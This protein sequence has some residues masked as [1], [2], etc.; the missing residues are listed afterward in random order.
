MNILILIVDDSESDRVTY[1]RYLQSE[2]EFDY[3]FLEAET[4]EE[5]IE[6]WN[7]QS[8]QLVLVDI[9]LPDGSGLEL[10][11]V[12]KQSYFEPFLPVI[13]VTGL[14]D[15]RIAVEA[16][17]LGA[18]DYLVKNY[19]TQSALCRSVC[20][21]IKQAIASRQLI[22]LEQQEAIISQISLHIHEK[23]DLKDIYQS[24]V[25]DVREF[26]AADRVV[27]YKFNEDMS[28][29]IVAESVISPWDA[30]LNVQVIDTCFQGNMG[31]AYQSGKIFL[32][33]DIY[34]AN[35]T[36]CHLQLLER[37]QVRA[38]LVVPILLPEHLNQTP[39]L[40]GLLIAHQCS[41]PRFWE[42]SDLNLLKR[43]SV[44]L[45]IALQQAELYQDL[46]VMNVFLEEK[47]QERTKQLQL[48]TQVLEEIHD[49]VVTTDINGTILSWNR[50]AEKLYGYTEAEVLGRNVAFIYEDPETLQTEVITPL[51]EQNRYTTEISVISKS[52]KNL[53]VNLS[54]S[55]VK[56][57]QGNIT[58]LI[59]CSNDITKRKQA[60]QE[61]QQLNEALEIKVLERTQKLEKVSERLALALK[62]GAFGCW[63]WNLVQDSKIWDERM[64]ELY[65]ITKNANDA[66]SYDDW[67]NRLY[68][69]DRTSVE[70]LL[71]QSI[72]GE[73]EYDTEFRVLHLDGTIHFIKAYGVVVRDEQGNPQTMIGINFDISDRK[74][75]EAELEQKNI[76]L[77]ELV[78]LR[79]EALNFR[80][81]MS[82]M[83]VHDLRNPLS[84][85]LLSAEIIQ[86]YGDRAEAKPVLIRKAE[87]I[88]TSGKQLKNMIDSLLLMAKLESGKILFN[89]EPT[90]LYDLGTEISSD[91]ELIAS[92]QYIKLTSQL[93]KPGNN[94]LIDA[95]ILRRI[96]ENLLSNAV[97]FSPPNSE[98]I[99]IMEY[100]PQEH[101]RITVT[102]SGPGISIEKRKTIFEKFEIGTIKPNVS[103]IGLGLA[104]CKMAVDAQG[105]TL[106]IADNH[107]QGSIFILEI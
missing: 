53:Y 37:F 78:K 40:W 98:V 103:Q 19:I 104:F 11:N 26:L 39:R 81:D 9:H 52:G 15:E 91:F 79:E 86:K 100:L 55:V 80:E 46:Q 30:C 63:E 85:I 35:L 90:D 94:I 66:P 77:E 33:P 106:A 32:A 68:F 82:N 93:P 64:Y 99:L 62:S 74:N 42:E 89:L 92:S 41:G 97:K 87:Q 44:Q 59:G 107:P 88:L 22:R 96:I 51:L 6:L 70:T 16:M 65:G 95:T 13:A 18:K 7:F 58:H 29:V 45:A 48:Q 38:N 8:P 1:R 71:Q 105:G 84:A 83:I 69:E 75:A 24:V 50:G 76:Q 61:L 28:G 36:N 2:T 5:G 60:E 27:I 72:L 12:I 101:I 14:G 57:E 102:D 43:L 21:V 54:L 73:A 67:A 10:I 34:A 23:L 47:V 25:A 20:N 56:D 17:K 49:G 4:L 3:Q 31:G